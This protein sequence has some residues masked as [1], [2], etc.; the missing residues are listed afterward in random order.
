M[1]TCTVSESLIYRLMPLLYTVLHRTVG[2]N[3]D[4]LTI[5]VVELLQIS[6]A[7]FSYIPLTNACHFFFRGGSAAATY[8]KIYVR[9]RLGYNVK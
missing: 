2:I 1:H 6:V 3:L 9:E 7:Y 4:T 8:M 5:Y